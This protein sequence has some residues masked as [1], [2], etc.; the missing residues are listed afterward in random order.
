MAQH[1][2]P[3]RFHHLDAVRAGALLL[4]VVLHAS[5][6]F[7]PGF[8]ETGWPLSDDSTSIG[9]GLL[10]FVIHLFRMPLFFLVAGFFAR[11]LHERAGTLGLIRNRAQRIALP[12]VVF[13]FVTM[14]LIIL[15]IVWA[16]RQSNSK[17]PPAEQHS[18]LIGPPIPL[19][20]L[21]FLYLLLLL[22]ALVLLLRYCVVLIDTGGSM[23]AAAGQA[24]DWSL[25][26][27]FA[28]LLLSIP[29]AVSLYDAP[30][31]AE[32]QGIPSP[33]V[34]L[35]P[36]V[37]SLLS[38][39]G[40]FLVGWFLHRRQDTLELL[41]STWRFYLAGAVLCT[42]VSLYIAGIQPHFTAIPLAGTARALY[43]AA[44]LIAMW[45]AMFSVIGLALR[46]LSAPSARWRYLSDASYWIYLIHLPI[47]M[48]LQAWMLKWPLHWSLKLSLMLVITMA[49]LLASYRFLVRR[50]FIGVFLNGRKYPSAAQADASAT[51]A[52]PVAGSS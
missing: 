22:Y 4:G 31:W 38:Y 6:S 39:G 42:C 27:R 13:Y 21:W 16:A 44:Y 14:P 34:G 28:P 9:L 18:A 51:P 43:L 19:G 48:L 11:L 49:V 1:A 45:C 46:F 50:T 23:R 5:M 8:R 33:I 17:G 12:F 24:L 32:W 52:G 25:R 47:V 7:L 2:D 26:W 41:A 35:V 36:N 40:A 3:H 20:H 29:V 15:A 10:Y 37:P 30:W